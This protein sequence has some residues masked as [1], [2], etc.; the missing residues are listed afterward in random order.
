MLEI[1][2]LLVVPVLNIIMDLI[3]VAGKYRLTKKLGSGAFGEIFQG[4]A[5]RSQSEVAIKLEKFGI[6]MPQ[7][8]YEY[9]IYKHLEGNAGALMPKIYHFG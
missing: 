1:I 5:L 2:Y 9:Q 3:I 7:L 4:V 8:Q 6:K